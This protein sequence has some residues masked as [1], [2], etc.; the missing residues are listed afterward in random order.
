MTKTELKNT[1]KSLIEI[2]NE[3]EYIEFKEAKDDFEFEK[4]GKY[5]SAIS[6]EANL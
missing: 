6:N 1:L 5:F 2:P 4:L 3:T